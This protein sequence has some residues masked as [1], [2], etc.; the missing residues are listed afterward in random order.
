MFFNIGFCLQ[1]GVKSMDKR[2]GA[3]AHNWGTYKDEMW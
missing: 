1:S 2:N 3:G